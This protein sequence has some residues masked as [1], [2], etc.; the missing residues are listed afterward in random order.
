MI[1]GL[2]S[3]ATDTLVSH[4][5]FLVS[6]ALLR[7]SES[8]LYDILYLDPCRTKHLFKVLEVSGGLAPN[9]GFN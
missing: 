7:M 3:C 8:L 2:L 9:M 6:S 4:D 1:D 5:F